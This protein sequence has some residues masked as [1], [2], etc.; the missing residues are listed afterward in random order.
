V[1]HYDLCQLHCDLLYVQ[2]TSTSRCTCISIYTKA[3]FTSRPPLR[4]WSA[5]LNGCVAFLF[6]YFLSGLCLWRSR[7]KKKAKP[8]ESISLDTNF[9]S[10]PCGYALSFHFISLILYSMTLLQV[11]HLATSSLFYF[12]LASS[13]IRWDVFLHYMAYIT[14]SNQYHAS[15]ATKLFE[16]DPR[17]NFIHYSQR[18]RVGRFCG[19]HPNISFHG[20]DNHIEIQQC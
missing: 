4:P 18:K 16:V 7:W 17:G 2:F 6:F 3:G 10:S 14:K 19:R 8:R 13:F 11:D 1:S 12:I 20:R 15:T 9:F 5:L